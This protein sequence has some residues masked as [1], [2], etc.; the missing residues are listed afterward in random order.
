MMGDSIDAVMLFWYT[1]ADGKCFLLK[2]WFQLL[3]GW[4]K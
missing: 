3:K 4:F 2:W 1:D